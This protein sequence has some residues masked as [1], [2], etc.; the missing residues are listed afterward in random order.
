MRDNSNFLKK[1]ISST[2]RNILL[3]VLIFCLFI[4]I[5][6]IILRTTHLFGAKISWTEP[7]PI[8]GWRYTPGRNYWYNKENNHPIIGKL[9]SYG[10]RDKEW[11]L[12]KPQNSYRIAVLGDSFVEAFQVELDNTFL[13]L[14]EHQLND[15][16]DAKVELMNFGRSGF[17]QT[18]ELL[19]LKNEIS[20][21]FPDM[22]ILFFL[23][24]NDIEEISKE[25]SSNL[26]RPFYHISDTEELILDTSFAKAREF[27][28]RSF[29]NIVKQ[30]SAL[31]SLLTERYIAYK[32]QKQAKT[33]INKTVTRRIDG[34]SSL[35]TA[36]PDKAYL[37]SYHLNKILIKAMSE[38][39][40]EK[41][42]NFMLVVIET[43][44]YIPEIEEKYKSV[45]PTFNTNFF[46]DDLMNYAKL[47]NIEYLGLQRIFR[48]YYNTSGTFLHWKVGEEYGHWNYQGHKLVANTLSN[49]LKSIVYLKKQGV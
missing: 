21:F 35:C 32:K 31:I 46:E 16:H 38:Y 7:D 6:E 3:S 10:W 4:S 33:K 30:H 17:T 13:A 25:T 34:S 36:N 28:I 14:T 47:L 22:V 49:K 26:G 9:N 42:I 44:A 29:I 23:P 12:K 37:R 1:F 18:E 45:H 20:R 24:G 8:L 48:Q 15:N 2:I 39:C 40:R 11:S 41:G 27:K 5:F 19:V 43:K